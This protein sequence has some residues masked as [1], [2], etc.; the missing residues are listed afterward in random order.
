MKKIA[1]LV[2]KSESIEISITQTLLSEQNCTVQI[3]H[4]CT[5]LTVAKFDALVMIAKND[6]TEISEFMNLDQL[7]I[8]FYSQ[9]KPIGTVGLASLYAAKALK[10]YNPLITLGE[11]TDQ[12]LFY[13]LHAKKIKIQTEAC[14]ADDYITDRDCKILSTPGSLDLVANQND[15][16]KGIRLLLKE[17]IEMS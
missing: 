2:L 4:D 17:L 12:N 16:T 3:F 7:I 11:N 15:V 10:K 6:V 14:P 13:N 9:V 1:F 5:N 8:D